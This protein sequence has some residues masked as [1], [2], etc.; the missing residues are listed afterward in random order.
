MAV[1]EAQSACTSGLVSNCSADSCPSGA[2]CCATIM[3]M[4]GMTTGG[5][6][7]VVGG[8]GSGQQVCSTKTPCPG[9]D[10]CVPIGGGISICRPGFNQPDGGFNGPDGGFN[11]PDGGFNFPDGGFNFPDG[12]FNGPDGAGQQD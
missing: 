10:R 6:A 12:G 3:R 1:C 9:T 4:G 5:T 11:F 8:C 7:C 2:L